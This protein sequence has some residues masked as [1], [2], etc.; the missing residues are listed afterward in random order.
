MDVTTDA[1]WVGDPGVRVLHHATYAL[2]G[3]ADPAALATATV[4]SAL[5]VLGPASAARLELSNVEGRDV[6]AEAGA[7][8]PRLGGLHAA[9][10]RTA[11]RTGRS[12]SASVGEPSGWA[13][14]LFP[15]VSAEE[16]GGILEVLAPGG[17]LADAWDVLEVLA[18]QAAIARSNLEQRARLRQ[19]VGAVRGD[20]GDEERRRVLEIAVRLTPREREI[21]R[22]LSEGGA[23]RDIAATLH[24]APNTVRSHVQALLAKLQVH[25]RLGAVAFATRHGL[26][27]EAPH[28]G[29]V[30]ARTGLGSA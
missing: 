15:L 28:R 14:G 30:A 29:L 9:R 6:S 19:S 27:G 2:N 12:T 21:L 5:A 20:A 4:G 3:A 1:A 13:V 24:I 16:T 11:L 26:L 7:A 8:W 25:T 10:R 23:T 18:A 22:L 17:S